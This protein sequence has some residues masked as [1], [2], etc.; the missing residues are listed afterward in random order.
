MRKLIKIKTM[1]QSKINQINKRLLSS[2]IK[3]S[4]L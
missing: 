3:V 2:E 1:E 4:L